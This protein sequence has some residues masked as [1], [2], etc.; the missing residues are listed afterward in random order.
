MP[1]RSLRQLFSR[2]RNENYYTN[3]AESERAQNRAVIGELPEVT[4]TSTNFTIATDYWNYYINAT[5]T[6]YTENSPKDTK[7]IIAQYRRKVNHRLL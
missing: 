7:D 5:H 2:R 6:A 1:G 3:R 4:L